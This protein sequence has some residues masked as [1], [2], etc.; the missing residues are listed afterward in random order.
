MEVKATLRYYR[1]SPKKMKLITDLI[2][3]KPVEKAESILKFTNKRGAKPV[4]KLLQS[5]I[6]N[7]QNNYDI[8]DI[9]NLYVKRVNLGPGP[10]FK[11]GR[12]APMGRFHLYKHRTLHMQ[13]VL[14]QK[15]KKE[16]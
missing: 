12:P 6:A 3:G 16:E 11:R 2:K 4:L 8:R 13:I 7:A 10:S 1:Y 5:A 15:E 9:E 14:D